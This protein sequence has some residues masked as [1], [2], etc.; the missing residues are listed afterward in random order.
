MATIGVS[1]PYYAKYSATGTSVTYTGGGVMGKAT[2]VGVEIE[3]TEDNNLYADNGIAE[4]DRQFSG[5]TLT[6]KPDDL[7]QE[8][9]KA[10][11]G[12]KEQK[13]G[14]IDGVTDESV[15]ELIYDDDQV[16]PYLGVGFI[17]KKQ[18]KGVTKWRAV[19]LTR[20]MFSVPA[21]AATTQGESIEWQV[22]ELSATITRDESEKHAWKKEATFT[23]EAQAEAYIKNRLGI[24][25]GP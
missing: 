25:E 19:V 7:S 8:V 21:D 17:I 11:L 3:T 16:T 15:M 24:T 18:V 1:K 2:E 23:T 9:S 22:P 10:I 12:L 13:V 5:G 20:V 14:T 4:T 6:V